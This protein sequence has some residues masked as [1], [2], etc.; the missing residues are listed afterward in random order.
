M[1]SLVPFICNLTLTCR[2]CRFAI[3]SHAYL[4]S[5]RAPLSK[6]LETA[7]S[8][9]YPLLSAPSLSHRPGAPRPP[10]LRCSPDHCLSVLVLIVIFPPAPDGRSRQILSNNNYSSSRQVKACVV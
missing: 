7:R 9:R 3:A 1:S 2:I 4:R 8:G 6:L 5:A 10:R